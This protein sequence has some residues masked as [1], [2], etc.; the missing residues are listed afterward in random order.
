[1]FF[2]YLSTLPDTI[3]ISFFILLNVSIMV[4]SN[5]LLGPFIEKHIPVNTSHDLIKITHNALVTLI[6]SMIAF[7]MIQARDNF[8]SARDT[9]LAEVAQINAVDVLLSRYGT[10]EADEYRQD[11]LIYTQSVVKEDWPLLAYGKGSTAT[12]SFLDTTLTNVAKL[13]PVTARESSM[14]SQLLRGLDSMTSA[15][16]ARIRSSKNRIP[17]IFWLSFILLTL[18]INLAT[19]AFPKSRE[20]SFAL[21]LHA[22]VLAAL[23]AIIFILDHPFSGST[24]ISPEP[25]EELIVDMKNRASIIR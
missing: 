22:S 12:E 11:L 25:L 7:S 3:V 21:T 5:W 20:K 14:H 4:L 9:T 10:K 8:K 13:S 16:E 6:A 15:R 17:R 18:S 2:N 23:I 1:M 24:W 19:S